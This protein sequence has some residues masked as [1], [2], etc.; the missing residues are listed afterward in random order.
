MATFALYYPLMVPHD[1]WLEMAALYWPKVACIRPRGVDIEETHLGRVLRDE[2]DFL[3][4]VDPAAAAAEVGQRFLTVLQQLE[5]ELDRFP[6]FGVR[7]PSDVAT[8]RWGK[9]GTLEDE[10]RWWNGYVHPAKI[11]EQV[12]EA[13]LALGL[14][15]TTEDRFAPWLVMEDRLSYVYMCALAEELARRDALQPV[16][17]FRS[18]YEAASNWSPERIAS[19]L[20]HPDARLASSPQVADAIGLLAVRAVT[21]DSLSYLPPEKLVEIRRRYH[22]EFRAFH[23]ELEAAAEELGEQF[24]EIR[25]TAVLE[26]YLR[27]EVEAGSPGRPRTSA[28]HCAGSEWRPPPPR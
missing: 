19:A 21:P 28:R 3:V 20:L 4:D 23:R 5:P 10:V 1:G 8:V 9:T 15:H 2:L 17:D 13:F 11:S 16:T 27:D 25:D 6:Y 26:A 18:F 12:R 22:A 24:S 14:A 7:R